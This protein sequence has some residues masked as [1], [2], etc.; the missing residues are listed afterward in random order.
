M[1]DER[2]PQSI[3]VEP[4]HLRDL[5]EALPHTR[6]FAATPFNAIAGID[7]VERVTAKAGTVLV[8]PGAAVALLLA[9]AR[10][11]NRAERPEA[12]EPGRW[13]GI[14]HAGEGFGEVPLLTGK[15]ASLFRIFAAQDSVLVRF[16]EQDFWSLLACCPAVRKVVLADMPQRCRLTR[17]RRCT[18][19]SS[20]PWA[21]SPRA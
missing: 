1:Q 13:S 4:I 14:A 9:G 6:I 18:A 17:S 10:R 15:T 8:E 21:R 16:S 19:K 2:E 7:R 11:R 20:S 12:M 3:Q 5:A